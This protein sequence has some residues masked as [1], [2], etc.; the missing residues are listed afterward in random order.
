MLLR[1]ERLNG[2]NQSLS[3]VVEKAAE[4]APFDV[5]VLEGVRTVE[6]QKELFAIGRTKPGKVVTW[7]MASKHLTGE[8][9]DLAPII[10]KAIPWDDEAKFLELGTAMFK[11]A[12][13]LGVKIRWG[14]DWDQDGK[15][16][17][18]GESDGPHFELV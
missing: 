14:Y 17:E 12:K 10:N 3:K 8:A 16:R 9:V 11:A 4:Y 5:Q 6:R 13:E 18:R 15:L 1:K 2:V 7:T